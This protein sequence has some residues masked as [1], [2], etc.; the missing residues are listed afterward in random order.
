ML[1]LFKKYKVPIFSCVL[2]LVALL[3]YSAH[4]RHQEK[5]SLFEKMVLVLTGPLQQGIDAVTGR[6]SDT[7][8]RY[9][10]LIHTE[11]ENRRLLEDNKRLQ[12]EVVNLEE[13]R[14]SNERLRKL[15]DFRDEIQL[16]ALPAKVIG[17][18]ASGWFRTVVIDRGSSDGVREGLAVVVAEGAVGRVISVSPLNARVLLI[19]DPSSAVAALVQRSRTRGVAR[20]RGDALTFDFALR[21]RDVEVG[22]CIIS[23]GTGGVFPKG[24]VLGTVTQVA[25][26]DYGM[27]QDVE[28]VPEVDFE[29]LEEVLVLLK[30]NS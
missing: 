14:L 23:S 27:F 30:E 4:L 13:A 5:T 26:E 19:V 7:W 24:I 21:E 25:R 15:L 28:I 1:E 3:V 22:D 2:V 18:D 8:D 20:G 11:E 17:E 16:P 9:F 12:A 29:K 6:V 10:W